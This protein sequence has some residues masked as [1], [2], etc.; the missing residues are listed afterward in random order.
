MYVCMCRKGGALSIVIEVA[1]LKPHCNELPYIKMLDNTSGLKFEHY[2]AMLILSTEIITNSTIS[3]K[4]LVY[5][6]PFYKHV[7][8]TYIN[9][10]L[11]CLSL[12]D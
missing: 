2:I 12:N 9:T 4:L 8:T 5:R 6:C 3:I 1:M 10:L 7:L 11:A